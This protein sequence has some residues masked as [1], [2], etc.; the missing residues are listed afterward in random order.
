MARLKKSEVIEALNLIPGYERV[1]DGDYNNLCRLL[2][3]R[4]KF[5]EDVPTGPIASHPADITSTPKPPK[6]IRLTNSI[7]KRNMFRLDAIRN[8]K[9]MEVLNKELVK[10][11][12]KGKIK[13]V[14]TI[15]HMDV[16]DRNWVTEFIIELKE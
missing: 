3:Q 1:E 12:H 16:I 5:F 13:T 2:K 4:T 7:P 8:E 11:E 9:D 6:Q 15:K 14:T 10:R